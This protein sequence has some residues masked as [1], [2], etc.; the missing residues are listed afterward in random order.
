MKYN[1]SF[2][3]VLKN[4]NCNKKCDIS[5]YFGMTILYNVVQE[6]NITQYMAINY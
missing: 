3:Y 2:F 6:I 5:C 4:L 1:H